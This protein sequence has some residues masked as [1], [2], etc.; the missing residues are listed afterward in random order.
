MILGD[1]PLV[2]EVV[3]SQYI[4]KFSETLLPNSPRLRTSCSAPGWNFCSLY[5]NKSSTEK[6]GGGGR[7]PHIFIPSRLRHELSH[8]AVTKVL[9]QEGGREHHSPSKSYMSMCSEGGALATVGE[10]PCVAGRKGVEY[11]VVPVFP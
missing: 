3:L 11:N 8:M 4:I 2:S 7:R 6:L 10:E 9:A 1:K 5:Q